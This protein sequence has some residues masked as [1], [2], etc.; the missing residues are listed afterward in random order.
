[1]L[2]PHT[3]I[4][5]KV[6]D[7]TVKLIEFIMKRALENNKLESKQVVV[8][9]KCLFSKADVSAFVNNLRKY[10]CI[11]QMAIIFLQ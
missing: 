4:L 3:V 7:E 6:N 2:I 5:L 8:Y 10:S 11:N 1:M 9:S